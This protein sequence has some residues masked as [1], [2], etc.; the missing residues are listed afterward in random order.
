MNFYVFQLTYIMSTMSGGL[1]L[2]Q[3]QINVTILSL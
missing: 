2:K 1:D 3:Q